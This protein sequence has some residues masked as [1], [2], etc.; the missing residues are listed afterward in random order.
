MLRT[1][2]ITGAQSE[3]SSYTQLL[4]GQ[5]CQQDKES[6]STVVFPFYP[7]LS[8]SDS[9][10]TSTPCPQL[11]TPVLMN[12]RNVNPIHKKSWYHLTSWDQPAPWS[13]SPH[14]LPGS[15]TNQCVILHGMLSGRERPCGSQS[16]AAL[17]WYGHLLPGG[18]P[19]CRK[20]KILF[21]QGDC[22]LPSN[23]LEAT[24]VHCHPSAGLYGCASQQVARTTGVIAGTQK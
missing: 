6:R 22:Q 15:A 8:I 3:S 19:R 9:S 24:L 17:P 20:W 7:P 18:Q 5:T 14:T 2:I 13:G 12:N 16:Q 23:P 4:L 1:Q 11:Q 10:Q 21:E